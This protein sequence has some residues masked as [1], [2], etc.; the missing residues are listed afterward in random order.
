[1]LRFFGDDNK[2]DDF[3]RGLK[4]GEGDSLSANC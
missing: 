1:N 4:I 2:L 3:R